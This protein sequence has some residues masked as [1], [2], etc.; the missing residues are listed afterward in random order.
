M[1]KYMLRLMAVALLFPLSVSAKVLNL[2]NF[3]TAEYD[4]VNTNAP[5]ATEDARAYLPP[6]EEVHTVF[7][8]F[9]DQGESPAMAMGKSLAFLHQA[10]EKA[11]AQA[12]S[13]SK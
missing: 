1:K 10:I 12:D 4:K 8:K 2:Y 7:D 6:I 3:E 5:L 11:K 9:I 13:A